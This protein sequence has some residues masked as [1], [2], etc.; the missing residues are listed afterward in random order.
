VRNI[1]FVIIQFVLTP[2]VWACAVCGVYGEDV[3]NK[4]FLQGTALLSLTPLLVIGSTV[5]YI[6]RRHKRVQAQTDAE[7]L[8]AAVPAR[9][10]LGLDQL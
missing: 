5:Y 1:I 2:R 10:S 7:A 3:S 8:S 9:P 6:Y 4:P